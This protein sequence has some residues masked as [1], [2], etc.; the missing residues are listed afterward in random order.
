MANG[1]IAALLTAVHFAQAH[2]GV[3]IV[4]EHTQYAAHHITRFNEAPV[5][6]Q[7]PPQQ[8]ICGRILGIV[9]Q[10]VAAVMDDLRGLPSIEQVF[11]FRE[12]LP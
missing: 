9:L 7:C 10:D 1:I 5:G 2:M 8:T 4:W 11:K 12:V 6:R 3:E